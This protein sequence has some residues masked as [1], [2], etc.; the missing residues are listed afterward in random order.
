[1][2]MYLMSMYL[3][4]QLLAQ[5]SERNQGVIR[6]LECGGK[7]AENSTQN[8]H[9]LP[10]NHLPSCGLLEASLVAFPVSRLVDNPPALVGPLNPSCK[11]C[12]ILC[13]TRQRSHP[14]LSAARASRP[15]GTLQWLGTGYDAP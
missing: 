5:F 11:F 12:H 8:H 2:G 6:S 4:G 13:T 3:K 7:G 10:L 15:E 14:D 9:F 1:M